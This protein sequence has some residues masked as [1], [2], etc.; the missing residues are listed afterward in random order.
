MTDSRFGKGEI[1]MFKR[2]SF[3]LL[4]MLIS[5]FVALA[6][7]ADEVFVVVDGHEVIFEGQGASLIDGRTMVPVRGVFEQLGFHVEWLGETQEVELTRSGQRVL[8]PVGGYFFTLN[9]TSHALDVPAQLVGGR[10][11]LP[12][13]AV[14]RAVGYEVDWDGYTRTVIVTTAV[15]PLTPIPDPDPI[16]PQSRMGQWD[17]MTIIGDAN[18]TARTEAAMALIRNY[19]PDMYTWIVHYVGILRQHSFSGMWYWLDPPE[20]R[21][22]AGTYMASAMWLAGTIVHDAKHSVQAY[23]EP[24]TFFDQRSQA[25]FDAEYEANLYM[26]AFFRLAG[27]ANHYISHIEAWN[28]DIRN[29]IGWWL[30]GQVDW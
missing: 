7:Y 10:T 6:V 22:G 20:Y 12:I 13:A 4:T 25:W 18:F 26:L 11:L 15:F 3:T 16:P 1:F 14:I 9:G 19:A 29:G 27:G 30:D 28:R 17:G 8:I 2:L 24:E 23:H 21:I 5:T